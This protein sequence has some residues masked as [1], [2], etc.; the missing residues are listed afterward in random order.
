MKAAP[1]DAPAHHDGNVKGFGHG[2]RRG[3]G[4]PP[5]RPSIEAPR[6]DDLSDETPEGREQ[7]VGSFVKV[8]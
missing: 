8:D 4:Q 5:P 6:P 7:G 3:S 2:I 1:G